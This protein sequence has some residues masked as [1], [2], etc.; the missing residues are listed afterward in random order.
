MSVASEGAVTLLF[1]VVE[2]HSEQSMMFTKH[3]TP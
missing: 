3:F 2:E 1:V